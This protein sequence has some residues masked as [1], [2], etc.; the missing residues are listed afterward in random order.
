M[1][2]SLD[3]AW[4]NDINIMPYYLFVPK[5]ILEECGDICE[6]L[7]TKILP[8]SFF[9]LS[10]QTFHLLHIFAKSFHE[11]YSSLSKV[12]T[13]RIQNKIKV[14]KVGSDGS[15]TRPS[16]GL[17]WDQI[18]GKGLGLIQTL[19]QI[20]E[21]GLE[22]WSFYSVIIRDPSRLERELY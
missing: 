16:L 12:L 17:A 6:T 15:N 21:R 20:F 22:N 13:G 7:K 2:S 18:L 4:Q 11:R 5:H 8:R 14:I 10:N 9:P 3:P 1:G 19:A